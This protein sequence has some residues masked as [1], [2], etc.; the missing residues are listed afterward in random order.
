MMK[1][2]CQRLYRNYSFRGKFVGRGCKV[3]TTAIKVLYEVWKHLIIFDLSMCTC[4]SVSLCVCILCVRVYAGDYVHTLLCESV[5]VYMHTSVYTAESVFLLEKEVTSTLCPMSLVHT[6]HTPSGSRGPCSVWSGA[7]LWLI[8]FLPGTTAEC[9]GQ[10]L[11]SLPE[12]GKKTK[13]NWD[14]YFL[15]LLQ[16]LTNVNSTFPHFFKQEPSVLVNCYCSLLYAQ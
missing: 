5:W 13:I 11:Q 8:Y 2:L 4:T 7:T 12:G 16:G 3:Y 14:F 15:L 1:Q 10:H 9:G 6:S